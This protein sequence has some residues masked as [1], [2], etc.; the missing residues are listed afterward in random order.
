MLER[1]DRLIGLDL[2]R[3][4]AVVLVIGR[5]LYPV[6]SD[7]FGP[8]GAVLV[9]WQR[10]G[11]IGVDIFFVLSGFLVSGLLFGE[12]KKT[13][14]VRASRFYVRRGWKI[15]P[16]F[17]VMIAVTATASAL[18]AR[19]LRQSQL[20]SELTFLQ[21]YRLGMWTHTWSLAVEEH[22]YLVLPVLLGLLMWLGRSRALPVGLIAPA[23]ILVV[24]TSL[25]LRIVAWQ[26]HPE[27]SLARHVFPSHL[28]ADS[29]FIG[30]AIAYGYHFH[31]ARLLRMLGHRR[32]W[33]LVGGTVLLIPAFALPLRSTP[34]LYTVGFTLFAIAGG[35]L[36]I[37]VVLTPIRSGRVSGVLAGMGARSYSIY[38]WHIPVAVWG[39][40][41][42]EHVTGSVLG[43]GA[44]V[45]V[46]LVGSVV[47]GVAMAT[48]IEAPSMRLRDRW[49]PAH[50]PAPVMLSP[51]SDG[52]AVAPAVSMVPQIDPATT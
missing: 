45:A 42:V 11:W 22:F 34:F 18:G 39:F 46:Y 38:L 28:R 10:G 21:S 17:F 44:K 27:F 25:A 35:M 23:A 36:V 40:E 7:W 32:R 1:H 26:Q 33:L 41:L 20:L 48:L 2:L 51:G 47:V 31:H 9:A 37:A 14:R 24:L 15:Y 29:L 4:T 6:P 12:V 8:V 50:V 13:D 43:F 52:A 19:E 5:H 30:V 16:P 3:L 49:F